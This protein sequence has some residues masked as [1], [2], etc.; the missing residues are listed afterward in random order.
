MKFVTNKGTTLNVAFKK[1]PYIQFMMQNWGFHSIIT[2]A[3]NRRRGSEAIFFLFVEG[4]FG[5]T[6][7]VIHVHNKFDFM[8]NVKKQLI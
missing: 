8:P 7:Y 4:Q 3:S 5:K 6:V 2:Y 1:L